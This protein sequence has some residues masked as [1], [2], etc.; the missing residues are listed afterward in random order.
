MLKQDCHISTGI[1]GIGPEGTDKE[2]AADE[3]AWFKA[4]P[5]I[6]AEM[7]EKKRVTGLKNQVFINGKGDKNS[8]SLTGLVVP[9]GKKG[10]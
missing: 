4:H 1:K 9:P 8:L 2:R 6:P 7:R 3:T 10:S 5:V